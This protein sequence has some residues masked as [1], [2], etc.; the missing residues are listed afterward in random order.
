MWRSNRT[1]YYLFIRTIVQFVIN[2]WAPL[3]NNI[4]RVEYWR[5]VRFGDKNNNNNNNSIYIE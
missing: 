3:I 2:T 4:V 1:D 5:A